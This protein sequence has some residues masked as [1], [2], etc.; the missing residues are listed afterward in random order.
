MNA[1]EFLVKEHNRVRKLLENISDESHRYK[2][3]ENV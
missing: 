1:I 3:K 2:T